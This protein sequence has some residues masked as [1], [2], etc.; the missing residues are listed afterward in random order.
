MERNLT[1][2]EQ[3]ALLQNMISTIVRNKASKSYRNTA[4]SKKLKG[5]N[6]EYHPKLR[7]IFFDQALEDNQSLF[8]PLD[9]KENPNCKGWHYST[10]KYTV[11]A[12]QYDIIKS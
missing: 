8:L 5:K 4:V 7:A 10:S 9:F 3:Y 11:W 12:C 6:V 1:T 2:V